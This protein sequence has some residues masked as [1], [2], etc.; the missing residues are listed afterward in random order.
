MLAK[1]FFFRLN[2]WSAVYRKYKWV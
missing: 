2:W 1:I